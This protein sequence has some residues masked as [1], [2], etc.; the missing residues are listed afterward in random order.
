[1]SCFQIVFS[2]TGG[3]QKAADMLTEKL[4]ESFETIDILDKSE[5]YSN[6]S[7]SAEDVCVIAVPSFGGR[8]AA[9]AV[10]RIAA[11]KGNGAKA[12]LL[13]SFGARDY[14]D[15]LLE[16][17][18]TAV[19][20]E[21]V[22]IAAVAAETE[23]SVMRNFAKGR[24]DADDKTELFEFG[25]KIAAK[26][27]SGDI[28][29]LKIKGNRPYKKYDGIPIK[30][31][32]DLSCIACGICVARCPVG[33]IPAISP[34]KTDKKKCISCMRCIK[35]CPKSARSLNKLMVNAAALSMKGQFDNNRPNELII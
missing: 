14:E 15:T 2:P 24:P 7:F 31:K 11:M 27:K 3:T 28:G 30:P 18:D 29:E 22:P 5:D 21:F 9:P 1:M 16:L 4:C 20:A 10:E 6:Y 13:V 17:Y 23:H 26:I 35:V 12:V 34:E 8:A 33:A 25:E 19:S 32:A